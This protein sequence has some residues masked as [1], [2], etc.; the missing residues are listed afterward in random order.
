MYTKQHVSY[1]FILFLKIQF[2]NDCVINLNVVIYTIYPYV[3]STLKRLGMFMLNI[4]FG[5]GLF[6]SDNSSPRAL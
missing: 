4:E 6:K 5:K 1:S 2:W 3:F